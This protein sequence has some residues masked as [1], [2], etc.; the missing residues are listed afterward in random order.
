MTQTPTALNDLLKAEATRALADFPDQLKRGLVVF[1]GVEQIYFHGGLKSHFNHVAYDN[2]R[3]KAQELG[4]G[5]EAA[6]AYTHKRRAPMI[7]YHISASIPFTHALPLAEA[8][9]LVFNHELAHIILGPVNN[10]GVRMVLSESASDVFGLLRAVGQGGDAQRIAGHMMTER[11]FGAAFHGTI[12][13]L[14]V[15]ALRGACAW[16]ETVDIT[17]LEPLEVALKAMEIA[18]AS[19]PT[20][21]DIEE[22]RRAFDPLFCDRAAFADDIRRLLDI[23]HNKKGGAHLRDLTHYALIALQSGTLEIGGDVNLAAAVPDLQA[24]LDAYCAGHQPQAEPQPKAS[25]SS[26]KV[27]KRS[28]TKP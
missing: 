23:G 14:T 21:A 20:I 13:Y 24:A 19:A 3:H 22:I 12:D 2:I 15:A 25:S 18:E 6:Y 9:S 7:A 4:D 27:V 28:A 11:Y 1:N 10:A 26:G 17:K 16:L 5:E 8:V